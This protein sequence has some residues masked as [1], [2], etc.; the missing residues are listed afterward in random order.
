MGQV[1]R[2]AEVLRQDGDRAWS[3]PLDVRTDGGR[4]AAIGA[5]LLPK[6]E[7]DVIDAAGMLALPGL[8]NAHF[9]SPG[10]LMRGALDGLPLEVFMLYEVPP[11]ASPVD[12]R[13]LGYLR[14]LV[15]AMEM[16]KLGITTVMDDAF[17]V[18]VATAEGVDAICRAY[19]DIGMRARVAIDQ[20]NVVEYEKYPFLKELLPAHL[21]ARMDQA[22]RQSAEELLEL[23]AHLITTWDGAADGRLGAALSCSAPQRVT[24]P[25]LEALS[26]LSERRQLPFNIHILETKLQRVLGE[27]RYGRSLVRYAADHGALGRH[28]V[29]IHGIWIDDADMAILARQGTTVAHNPVCNLRLGSGIAPFRA[30]RNAG[31]EVCLGTD[32]IIADDSANLWG[33]MKT[34]GMV[35]TIADPDWRSWPKAGEILDVMWRGGARALG[36]DGEIGTL[37]AG[38]KAD[39]VLVDLDTSAF[40]PLNDL[41]RQLV[42]CETGSSVRH[43]MVDGAWV[44][45]DSRLTALDEA[46]VRAEIRD[47][48]RHFAPQREAANAAARELEPY[49]REMVLRAHARDVGLRRRL[50]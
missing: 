31:V 17:H 28:T 48:A 21:L 22:P 23:Y 39:I 25:Y 40:T 45:R 19:R 2:G 10:N 1:I 18:P 41:S 24:V 6:P 27:D 15:G 34:A 46:A 35:H 13:R 33:A 32:E 12:Q 47:I 44:V 37:K 16:L 30:W 4:I 49:Y 14:T 8:V 29:M 36:W 9:H 5:G 50:D 38:A 26:D 42:Y 7:D 11:L 20:P 43:V 3:E